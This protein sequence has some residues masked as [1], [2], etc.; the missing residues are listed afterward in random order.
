MSNFA[1]GRS[2]ATI[3]NTNELIVLNLRIRCPYCH[4]TERTP[5]IVSKF[6]EQQYY[7]KDKLLPSHNGADKIIG[8]VQCFECHSP[9]GVEIRSTSTSQLTKL[10]QSRSEDKEATDSIVSDCKIFTYPNSRKIIFSSNIPKKIQQPFFDIQEDV[11]KNRNAAGVMSIS[12]SCLDVALKELGQTTGGRKSRIKKLAEDKII[13]QGI[14]EWANKLWEDGND[15]VHDLNADMGTAKE[16]VEFLKL[17]FEV[18]FSLPERI[19][20]ASNTS[21]PQN[22]N[23][24]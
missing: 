7:S 3:V 6:Y 22:Q 9:F 4:H 19:A 21:D 14:A 13:T 11:H 18:A 24:T 5:F 10:L 2:S 15:A 20:R 16:H 12:R 8:F 1:N 23:P 17:F